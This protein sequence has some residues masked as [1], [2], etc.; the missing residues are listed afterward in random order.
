MD[1][2]SAFLYV[3]IVAV[4]PRVVAFVYINALQKRHQP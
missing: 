1:W 4:L 2:V 3:L